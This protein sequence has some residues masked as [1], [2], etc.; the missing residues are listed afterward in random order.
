MGGW[1]LR[2]M[3]CDFGLAIEGTSERYGGQEPSN[4]AGTSGFKSPEQGRQPPLFDL[5]PNV[6]PTPAQLAAPR[7]RLTNSNNVWGI[8]VVMWE[9]IE[10]EFKQGPRTR[11]TVREHGDDSKFR[12]WPI[13]DVPASHGDR[14]IGFDYTN[15]WFNQAFKQQYPFRLLQLV[16]HCLHFHPRD[17]PSLELLRIAI[18]QELVNF[19]DSMEG[20]VS[21]DENYD[22]PERYKGQVYYTENPEVAR[23]DKWLKPTIDVVYNCF[24]TFMFKTDAHAVG[25]TLKTSWGS[26][27]YPSGTISGLD[28][29]DLPDL[30]KIWNAIPANGIELGDLRKYFNDQ[31]MPDNQPVRWA[32]SRSVN[33]IAYIDGSNVCRPIEEEEL[34]RLL[35]SSEAAEGEKPRLFHSSEALVHEISK[36]ETQPPDLAQ[37]FQDDLKFQSPETQKRKQQFAAQMPAENRGFPTLDEI[38]LQIPACGIDLDLL[39]ESFGNRIPII[40]GQTTFLRLLNK[41]VATFNDRGMVFRKMP[42]R[43]EVVSAI[44]ASP[45][46]F[47]ELCLRFQPRLPIHP[48]NDEVMARD[49]IALVSAIAKVGSYD[50]LVLKE[51]DVTMR[52]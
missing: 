36:P 19:E 43:E 27:P 44:A 26:D 46:T 50:I 51:R 21:I 39:V 31:G 52:D 42:T 32:F 5:L 24:G 13:K 1:G 48:E 4:G 29:D 8:G 41:D 40:G 7:P 9:L 47:A 11:Y 28:Y 17:R 14:I 25:K 12:L 22:G 35:L 20:M 3:I 2:P 15:L 34:R 38:L 18:L 10:I 37:D 6:R 49:F 23:Y 16:Q 33:Q 30:E 45:I